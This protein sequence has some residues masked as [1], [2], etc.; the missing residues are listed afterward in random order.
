MSDI[1]AQR[2]AG[3]AHRPLPVLAITETRVIRVT[4]ESRLLGA[5][6]RIADADPDTAKTVGYGPG[7][8]RSV[9]TAFALLLADSDAADLAERA[10]RL[11]LR[12]VSASTLAT[13]V[14][15]DDTVYEKDMET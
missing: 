14:L 10:L 5:A 12:V 1:P 4:D 9:N 6:D 2:H 8:T 7:L 3:A 13:D 11:G 15:T